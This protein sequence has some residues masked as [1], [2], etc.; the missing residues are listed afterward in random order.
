MCYTVSPLQTGFHP[1]AGKNGGFMS[2]TKQVRLYWVTTADHDEDWFIFAESARQARS[3]H[4]NYEGYG[5][6][7][8]RAR[9]IV[10]DV[11]LT[12]FMNGEP[13]CHAQ[14][15]ELLALG[16]KDD[17]SVP[18]QRSVHFEGKTY[19]EGSLESLVELGRQQLAVTMRE[20]GEL[21]RKEVAS[22]GAE[23]EDKFEVK[24]RPSLVN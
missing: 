17:G 5:V 12:K 14:M 3:Y 8:A 9:L 1:A 24:A 16:F 2:S 19:T 15:R 11:R 22:V 6:G 7:D 4:E 23:P 13:P 10:R 20:N 21:G 18:N